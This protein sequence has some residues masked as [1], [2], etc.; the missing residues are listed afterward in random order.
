MLGWF[1]VIIPILSNLAQLEQ[2]QSNYTHPTLNCLSSCLLPTAALRS[3]SCL[4]Y[5][6]LATL[7]TKETRPRHQVSITKRRTLEKVKCLCEILGCNCAIPSF[8]SSSCNI[9][10]SGNT[11]LLLLQLGSDSS[12][13][14]MLNQKLNWTVIWENVNLLTIDE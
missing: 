8:I 4:L 1:P 12:K 2:C 10:S 11:A 5:Q 14:I 9:R 6:A 13:K 7:A 3:H